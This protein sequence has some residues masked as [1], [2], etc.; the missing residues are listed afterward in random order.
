MSPRSAAQPDLAVPSSSSDERRE[1]L[2]ADDRLTR[3]KP[4]VDDAP[5]AISRGLGVL[6]DE[7][8]LQLLRAAHQGAT[9]FSQFQQRLP[10]SAAS[11][12]TRLSLLSDEGLFTRQI[13]QEHPIRAE[14]ILSPRGRATWPIL[15]SIW[16]WERT[17]GD[18]RTAELPLMRHSECGHEFAPR[19]VC[20]GCDEPVELGRVLAVWGPA[21]GWSRSLPETG[22]RR[23]SRPSRTPEQFPET[24]AVF[25]NRWSSVVVGAVFQ[26]LRHYAEFESALTIPS[27]VLSERLRVLVERG[28]LEVVDSGSARAEYRLTAKG[29]A[30]FPVIALT[31]LWSDQW[32]A[33]P[34]GAAMSWQH[35]DHPLVARLDC[36]HCDTALTAAAIDVVP[37]T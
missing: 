3:M 7:W 15:L 37:R 36:D 23:R 2:P 20:A 32:F 8:S 6:G 29:A 28:F 30:F 31:L 16:D 33:D 18:E 25:G 13:Y 1:Q 12:A 27:N 17:W 11:L 26:G 14:Y 34:G 21:G 9:R 35:G 4:P 10:I 5:N 19:L 22:T 24:M